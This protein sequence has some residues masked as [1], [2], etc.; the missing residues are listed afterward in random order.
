MILACSVVLF[1]PNQEVIENVKSLSPLFDAV[2]AIDN[3]DDG[4]GASKDA[5]AQYP[6]IDFISF[7][8][9]TGIA[10][11]LNV[12][13]EKSHK[14]DASFL[15]T[16]D[17]DSIYP[18]K[19]HEKIKRVLINTDQNNDAIIGL[20]TN[21]ANQVA[22]I[23]T[24]KSIITSGNFINVPLVYKKGILFDD[25]LFIDYVDFDFDHKIALAGLQI[26]Q[27]MDICLQHKIGCP[28]NKTILG[29]HLTS[30]NHTPE[31]DYYRYRNLYFLYKTDRLFFRPFMREERLEF[32]RML[33]LEKNK[34]KKTKMTL[35]GICDGKRGR[36]GKLKK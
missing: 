26:K 13:L 35:R 20:S 21:P 36:L 5:F 28:I 8:D 17:Q 2:F 1:H 33:L 32:F 22:G 24:V 15:C 34:M 9:N 23:Q 25:D 4:K 16:L 14:I 31:R 27:I 10:H 12:A 6:N 3:S 29:K 18:V 7:G 30:M 19:D 11:A